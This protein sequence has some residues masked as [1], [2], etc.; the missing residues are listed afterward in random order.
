[1]EFDLSKVSPDLKELNPDIF[2]WQKDMPKKQSK[3]HNVRQ[4]LDGM[5]F[6]S[7]KE[8]VDA[9][10]FMLAVRAGEYIAYLH[11]VRF[12]LAGGIVYEADHVLINNDLTV[13]VFDS[14][15]SNAVITKEYRLKRKLFRDRYKKEIREI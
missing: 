12:S 7:G 8:A 3:Y 6:D 5:S 14:K 13:D 11:H 1:M 4:T 15:G 10:N 2:R 9:Q